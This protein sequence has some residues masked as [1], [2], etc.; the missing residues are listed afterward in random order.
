MTRVHVEFKRIQTW[1]FA[2][3]RL[4][5]M[6][7]A[8]ALLGETL[9]VKLPNLAR[10][11]RR[12]WTLAPIVGTYPCA[13]ANDPLASHDDPTVDAKDGCGSCRMCP[14]TAPERSYRSL[15]SRAAGYGN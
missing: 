8:N 1:L 15:S 5:A 11:A 7:G 4:R 13:D 6:V 10:E 9:R 14:T 12:P 2:V 3:P